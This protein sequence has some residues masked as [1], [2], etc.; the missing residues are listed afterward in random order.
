MGGKVDVVKGRIKEA[1]GALIGNDTLREEG[2]TDQAVGKAKQATQKAIDTVKKGR[3]KGNWVRED[4]VWKKVS[5]LFYTKEKPIMN[6]ANRTVRKASRDL[7]V[8]ILGALGVQPQEMD[9]H[10][11]EG[12]AGAAV[13]LRLT[14]FAEA[15][16]EQVKPKPLV[17]SLPRAIEVAG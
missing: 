13:E 1:A 6:E 15:I 4:L 3:E 2:K 7:A 16:L 12:A 11:E 9:S 10:F 8:E 14:R 17:Q 5:F